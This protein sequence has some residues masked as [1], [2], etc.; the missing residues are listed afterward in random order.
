MDTTIPVTPP[1]D[2][3][4]RG[5]S[6]K[7]SWYEAWVN[8]FVGISVSFVSNWVILPVVMGVPMSVHQNVTLTL[9]FTAV[10]LVRSYSLCRF[11]NWLH[12]KGAA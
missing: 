5:Q 6:K 3:I 2:L 12:V 10:S 4:T 11:F 8:V 7:H 9:F 1:T